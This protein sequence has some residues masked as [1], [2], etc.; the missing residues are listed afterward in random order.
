MAKT[1]SK[2]QLKNEYKEY[3]LIIY[4]VLSYVVDRLDYPEGPCEC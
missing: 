2:L 1:V 3:K 4:F